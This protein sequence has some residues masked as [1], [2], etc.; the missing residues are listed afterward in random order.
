[1]QIMKT[2]VGGRDADRRLFPYFKT[3]GVCFQLQ[4]GG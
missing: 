4:S 3:W 2:K 1:M